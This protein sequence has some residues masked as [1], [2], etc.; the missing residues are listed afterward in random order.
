[1]IN[2]INTL[3]GN[4]GHKDETWVRNVDSGKNYTKKLVIV[5]VLSS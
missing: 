2:K 3:N 1:M 5:K 4:W